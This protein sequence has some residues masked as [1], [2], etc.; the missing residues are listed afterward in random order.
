LTRRTALNIG[1]QFGGECV[2]G[3]SSLNHAL[4]TRKVTTTDMTQYMVDNV[5]I[6]TIV[7][8]SIVRDRL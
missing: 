7:K 6:I 1:S 8:K 5:N 3:S 2:A 4:M